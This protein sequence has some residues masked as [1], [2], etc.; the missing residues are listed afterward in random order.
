ML[1]GGARFFQASATASAAFIG[2][3]LVALSVVNQDDTQQATRE[4]RTVLAGS[5]FLALVDI[6]FVSM[7]SSLGG[8]VVLATTSLV[9]AL[10]G[11]A[12]T[13]RLMPRAIRAGNFAPRLSQ[14]KAESGVRG[15]RRGHLPGPADPLGDVAE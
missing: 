14:P 11:L 2:L 8:A 3:L 12:G 10:L 4:R 15:H 6:F 13:S 9:M 5:N 1:D 7:V